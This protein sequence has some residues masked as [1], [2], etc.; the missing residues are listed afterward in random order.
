MNLAPLW[1]GLTL[2][3]LVTGAAE[4]SASKASRAAN[5]VILDETAVKNLRIE[6]AEAEEQ[7]FERTVFALGRIDVLPGKRTVISSRIAGRAV[8]V[9]ARPDHE[10]K[11]GDP[12]VVIESRQPGEPPPQ[13]TLTAPMDG[14]VTALAIAPG[15]PVNPDKP[16][17]ALVDLGVVYGL[18]RVPEHLA[19]QL[20]RGRPLRVRVPGW[21][22]EVWETTIEHLGTEAD[23]ASGTL[24]VAC[25]LA[26]EGL[27]L[28][29]G[30]RAEFT[31]VTGRRAGVLAVP[32]A[33]VQG[34]ATDRHVFL[35]DHELPNAFIRAPVVTGEENDRFTEIVNGLFA[36]D[37]VVTRSGHALSFAGKGT[38]SLKEALDAAHGH[39]HNE[40]GTEVS[41]PASSSGEAHEDHAH[42]HGMAGTTA[43]FTPLTWVFAGTTVVLL[44]VSA[45]AL[46]RRRETVSE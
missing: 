27:W 1:L 37:E 43:Q 6:T 28:R 5:T 25:H 20:L 33:A 26:N 46:R 42:A 7:T 15:E 18:A 41:A 17:L 14:F 30:M 21:P 24:E 2:G 9:L 31:L 3:C 22:G 38:V 19:D 12:L 34:S 16:L 10:V 32:R 45:F 39:A 29:P 44:F 23:P 8:K 36:G 4:L 11:A 40:D 13:I 35:K